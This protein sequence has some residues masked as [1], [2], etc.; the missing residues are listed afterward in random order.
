MA[1]TKLVTLTAPR[2]AAAEAY[3]TLRTNLMFSSVDKPITTLLVSSAAES[4]GKSSVLANLAVTFAQGGHKTI[5][6]DADLRKPMQHE[7]WG[8]PNERGLTTMMLDNATLSNPP[9]IDT[10]VPN[11]QLLL[12]GPL[13]PTPADLLGSQRM[14]EIIGVLKARAH[15]VL[16]DSPPVLAVTD[17]ALLGSKLD[18]VLLIARAGHTRREHAARAREALERVHV[19]IVGAVLTNAPRENTAKYYG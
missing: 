14:D 5:L 1:D 10:E 3:R 17:A 15:Y 12:A 2:S 9:L 7:I 4:E 11:L 8:Q 18:G 19:R 16:F 6:V 13:P